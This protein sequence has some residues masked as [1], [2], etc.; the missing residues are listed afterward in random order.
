MPERPKGAACKVAGFAYRGSN[1]LP[2]TLTDYRRISFWL[3]SAG[4]DLRPRPSLDG[5]HR[6]DVAV[7]GGG[8]TGLWTAYYLAR[9]EPS[10]R[11]AVLEKEICGFGAS[12]RNGGWCSALF[13]GSRGVTARRHGR[14][15]A[16]DLEREMFV[17][18]DEVGRVCSKESIDAHFRKSGT[19]VF[20]TSAAQETRL[21]EEVETERRWGF[22]P[23]DVRWLDAPEAAERLRVTGA[24]G[25]VF[26]PH[27]ATVHPARLVRGLAHAVERAGVEVYERT[28][29]TGIEPRRVLTRSGAVEARVIVRATEGYT[30]RLPGLRRALVPIYSLM[31][32]TEPLPEDVWREIGWSGHEAVSDGRHLIIYAQRT[33]D[34]RIAMGGR[35]APYHF[36]SRVD[37]SFD[38]E[39]EVFAEIV[40]VLRSLWPAASG[41]RITHTWGGP[42]GV[43]RDWYSSVGYDRESGIAWAGGYV[44]DGVATSNLAGRTLRDLILGRDTSITRLPWV[45]HRSRRWEPEPFRWLGANL[46]LR[47]MAWADRREAATGSPSRIADLVGKAIGR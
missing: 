8:Y 32:A 34:G 6:C 24:R 17:T 25:A 31:V 4:D 14:D 7:V 46:A 40:R 41:A 39:P 18:V 1:P 47:A 27:C 45:G 44:G 33:T 26:T 29:A 11:I 5:D 35:G 20:A 42:L 15:A 36:G 22:G 3:D 28:E 21:R 19:L 2:A 23:D 30:A 37:P 43:P 13:A 10:L 12:G 16:I 38:Q 9:A